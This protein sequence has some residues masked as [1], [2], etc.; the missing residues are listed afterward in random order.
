MD[1]DYRQ[2][3]NEHAPKTVDEIRAAAHRLSNEGYSERGIADALRL[4]I[5]AVR[6]LLGECEGL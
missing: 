2:R 4:D 1:D 3:A 6:R 5:S